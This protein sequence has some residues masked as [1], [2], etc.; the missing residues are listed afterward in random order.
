MGSSKKDIAS[1][2]PNAK[3]LDGLA[4][5]GGDVNSSDARKSVIAWIKKAGIAA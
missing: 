4:I 5:R 3:L 2:C 1:L